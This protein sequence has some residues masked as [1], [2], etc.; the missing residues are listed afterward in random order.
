M[1]TVSQFDPTISPDVTN[2]THAIVARER[3][4]SLMLRAWILSGL[5]FMALPGTLLG[6]SNLMAI[7]THHGLGA[8]PA[9]WIQGHGHAQVFG[10]IGSFILGIGFYSQP[11]RGRSVI[12][13]PLACFVLW[14]S[15]VAL[16]WVASIYGWHWRSLFPVSAGLEVIAVLLFLAAASRHKLPSP[17]QGQQAKSRMELWMVSVLL[18]TAGLTAAVIFNFVECLV[19]AMHGT[20][21]AFPHM[22]DQKYLV[23]LAWGFLV[24]FVWGFSARWLS[25]FL[26][27]S[28]PDARMYRAALILDLIGVLLGVSGWTKA[29]TVLLAL[30]AVAIV[31]SLHL[32]QRPHGPAKV[33]GIHRSFPVF[34]RLAYAWLVIAAAMSIWAALA[35][36][37]GGIWGASR[38]ALTV[39]FAATMVFAIGPRILPHFAGV[40]RIFSTRLMFLSLL[41]LQSGCTLRVLSEPLAYEGIVSSAWKTLPVSGI[42]ELGGVLVFA[43]NIALTMLAGKSAFAQA[44]GSRQTISTA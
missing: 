37:H 31:L 33:Q 21:R 40:H 42:L 22:L 1:A 26:A 24:P 19:L 44:D 34:I 2:S 43:V 32:T 23:L 25:T 6:F 16:R 20:L 13:I 15:G 27:I 11:A 35:D 10:W 5:F 29:A 3:Q 14:T 12:R 8:L 7:S 9:A 39:G 36:Q 41:L 28:K 18:G 38:H 30:S 17:A 4:K